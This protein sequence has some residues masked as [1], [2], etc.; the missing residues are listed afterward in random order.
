MPTTVDIIDAISAPPLASLQQVLDTNG[1]YGPGDHTLTQFATNGAFL[2]PAGSYSVSGTYGVIVQVNGV[3]PAS[4][5]FDIGWNDI[6]ILAS[7]DEYEQRIAQLVLLHTLPITGAKV[8]T[9]Q[10]DINTISQ[11]VFYPLL[12]G[13]AATIGLHVSPNWHVDLFYL[14][15]L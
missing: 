2:L 15:V 1:P 6:S 13:T 11:C 8:I 14:C 5:G 9:L 4:A 3:I 10:T 7:G 12:I